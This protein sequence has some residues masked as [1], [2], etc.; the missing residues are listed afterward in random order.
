MGGVTHFDLA[1][2]GSGSG[3]S[4]PDDRFSGHK[5]AILEKGTFG[6]TCLNVGCIPTKMF[7]YPAD[8]AYAA[9]HADPLGVHTSFD[10]ARWAE[11]R[12]RVFS[13]IDPISSSGR[14]WRATGRSNV[15]LFEGHA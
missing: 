6:G 9:A 5:V 4:I 12:D 7:V 1:I 13:R 3:N 2:I 11:I 15:T 8:Q 14:A 10:G